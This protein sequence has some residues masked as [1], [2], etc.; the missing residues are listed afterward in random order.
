MEM[1]VP[2]NQSIFQTF[3]TNLPFIIIIIHCVQKRTS[4]CEADFIKD[5]CRNKTGPNLKSYCSVLI[6]S[7]FLESQ[8]CTVIKTS[9]Y[10]SK[11]RSCMPPNPVY[12]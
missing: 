12:L 6:R 9:Q 11:I 5:N 2:I 10:I 8:K 1:S 3:G 4:G 7:L